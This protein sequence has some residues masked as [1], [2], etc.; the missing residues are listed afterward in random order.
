M[1]P[2][3]K[4]KRNSQEQP[5]EAR[6][7]AQ[8]SCRSWPTRR[9][10]CE[11]TIRA[12]AALVRGAAHA[13]AS[14]S[15]LPW[16]WRKSTAPS[17]SPLPPTT[18]AGKEPRVD[19]R[20]DAVGPQTRPATDPKRPKLCL[21]LHAGCS[22]SSAATISDEGPSRRLRN[23]GFTDAEV[24]RKSSA[25]HRPEYLFQLF[26][27]RGQNRSGLPTPPAGPRTPP[28]VGIAQSQTRPATLRA[29]STENRS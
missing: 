14:A 20:G 4:L 17:Y 12:D 11:P 26:Q 18:D 5:P 21:R 9:L 8:V 2:T 27:Q 13:P 25:K 15:R 28:L 24:C 16:P 29:R 1:A 6:G 23:A 22:S 3:R 10:R 7:S 19:S